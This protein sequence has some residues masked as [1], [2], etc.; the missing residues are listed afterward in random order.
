MKL[1]VTGGCGFIGSN[2]IHYL[3]KFSPKDQ[4]INLDKLT[5]AAN[6]ANLKD[7]ENNPRYQFVKGD[8]CDERIISRIFKENKI[9]AVVH[10]AAESHVDRSIDKP[11]D[12]LRTNVFGTYV[13]LEAA[14][15]HNFPKFVQI[16]CYD[17]KT[18]AVT[19]DGLK[20]FKEIKKGDKVFSL[21]PLTQKI[22]IKPVEKV[23]IQPYKGKMIHFKNQR[24]DLLVTPNH[25][26]F[27][28]DTAK[29]LQIEPAE[30]VSQRSVFY[31]PEG[32]WEGNEEENFNIEGHGQVKT[33]DLLYVLGVFIGDGF[34]AYQKQEKET[35]TGFVREEFFQKARDEKT[36]RFKE[37]KKQGNH[38]TKVET[39][40]IFFDI[41]EHDK[42]RQKLETALTSLGIKYQS[43]KGRAGTHLYFSSKPFYELFNQCGKGAHNKHIPRW[44]LDYSPK[45]LKYLL[46]GLMDADGS[47]GAIY[48]TVSKKLV[49]DF[50]E[51]CIKLNLKPSVHKKHSLSFM[52]DGRK[53]EGNYYYVFIANTTKSISR[54]RIKII[55][56]NG[57]I[58]CLKVKDNKNF[59]VERNGRFDFCGNTDEVYGSIK[60]GS[61]SE[62]DPLNPSSPYSSSKA[63]ADL[64]ALVY[65]K[66]YNLPVIITRSSN[67]FGPFQ[68]PEKF[69]PRLLT[70]ALLGK[71]LPVYGKGQNIRDWIYVEDN[72]RA[73]N[74][75]L[76]KGKDGEIY[77]IGGGNE[78]T[79]LEIAKEIQKRFP[80]VKIE[81]VADRPGHDF[82]YSLDCSKIQKL[83]FKP[84]YDFEKALQMTIAWYIQNKWWWQPLKEKSEK[85]YKNWGR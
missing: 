35:K 75:V 9:D 67:N 22:E 19:M 36:G 50:C 7:I 84:K 53:I 37:I 10:F 82:R 72:C 2:F 49:S 6:P 54:H 80:K 70:N 74:L 76:R 63:A 33:K 17:E 48:Y 15:R 26:M 60:K 28:W 25:N 59:L 51:L 85:I 83:G 47:R 39:Y 77:N 30:R 44:A 16:S 32:V 56:Y 27:I 79:N 8:I 20:T 81:F 69:I 58:W 68:F 34:T 57:N 62:T 61:F 73:I 12:F 18:R 42:A 11:V 52:D 14:K 24:I 23:I 38:K 5:Y 41:P 71:N 43:H 3:I 64:L 40:R 65:Y 29:R 1:L 13:L 55:D 66:T 31:M 46:D 45:Y 78:K 4:I 21:N